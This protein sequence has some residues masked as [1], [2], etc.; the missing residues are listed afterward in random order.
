ML[1]RK[2]VEREKRQ[3]A[4]DAGMIRSE[5]TGAEVSFTSLIFLCVLSSPS[6]FQ[7]GE[8]TPNSESD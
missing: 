7:S 5:I 6:D 8:R 2:Q 1:Y 4:K 3:L